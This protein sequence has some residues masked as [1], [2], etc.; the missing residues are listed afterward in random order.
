MRY[1]LT[2]NYIALI[3]QKI[4]SMPMYLQKEATITK[5]IAPLMVLIFISNFIDEFSNNVIFLA[6]YPILKY[7]IEEE[8]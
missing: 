3:Y 5:I 2:I 6:G 8:S 4:S 1:S 7:A